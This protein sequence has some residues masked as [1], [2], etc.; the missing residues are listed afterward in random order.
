MA[1]L[2]TASIKAMV[3]ER[4]EALRKE[5]ERAE[6]AAEGNV[7]VETARVRRLVT[8]LEVLK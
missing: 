8:E 4:E 7:A 3:S 2:N 1:T 6:A 5:H